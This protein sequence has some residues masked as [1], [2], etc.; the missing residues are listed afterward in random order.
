MHRARS[1]TA[2]DSLTRTGG[3]GR[4]PRHPG[5]Q[6]I[7]LRQWSASQGKCRVLRGRRPR[8]KYPFRHAPQD[9]PNTACH[10]S[11]GIRCPAAGGDNRLTPAVRP[12]RAH[13]VDA[14]SQPDAGTAALPKVWQAPDGDTLVRGPVIWLGQVRVLRS[15]ARGLIRME[16]TAEDRSR[17]P[18]QLIPR[19]GACP[20]WNSACWTPAKW[21]SKICRN[22][23]W[24]SLLRGPS[25]L[26]QQ[27]TSCSMAP[28]SMRTPR[29]AS[30]ARSYAH[31]GHHCRPTV[32]HP[33][34]REGER[35]ARR[36]PHPGIPSG[37]RD[38]ILERCRQ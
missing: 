11:F 8:L 37:D 17:Q 26:A 19:D 21:V 32:P 9:P 34:R 29:T 28:W 1:E 25:V 2:G 18:G 23:N 20:W 6:R 24:R 12:A 5:P 33:A 38:C 4:R 16:R 13:R 35:P 15:D 10:R 36:C 7:H 30:Y 14:C 31:S 27:W 22:W 3:E